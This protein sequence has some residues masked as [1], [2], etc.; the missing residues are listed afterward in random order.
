MA[1]K[2]GRPKG[3]KSPQTLEK[4]RV[5][6]E[7]RQRIMN[8][9][10]RLVDSQMSIATGQQFL[11]VIKT[12]TLNGKKIKKRPE[13]ITDELIIRDYLDGEFGDG[14]SINDDESY[15]FITTKEPNNIALDSMLDRAF[16]RSAQRIEMTGADGEPLKIEWQK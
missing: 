1:G 15:Y 8:K 5:L 11:Y 4:E 7:V 9:A 10:H 14:E 6:H 12:E 2:V 16:G 3:V 13:L